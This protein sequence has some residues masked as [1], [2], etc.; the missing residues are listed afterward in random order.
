[1]FPS[2]LGSGGRYMNCITPRRFVR[3]CRGRWVF[4]LARGCQR[5]GAA[6]G[7]GRGCPGFVKQGGQTPFAE[8]MRS[9]QGA[10]LYRRSGQAAP[11][12]AA[13]PDRMFVE[14]RH[15][16]PN[17]HSLP[18]LDRGAGRG[19]GRGLKPPGQQPPPPRLLGLSANADGL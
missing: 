8:S 5:R 13:A 16:A 19:V 1:M 15:P 7:G 14:S 12:Q 10:G 18:G 9:P 2:R 3:G 11:Q 17:A 4:V 6:G